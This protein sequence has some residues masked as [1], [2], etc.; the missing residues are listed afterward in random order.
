MRVTSRSACSRHHQPAGAAGQIGHIGAPLIGDQV[1]AGAQPSPSVW[2]AAAR[3][4]RLVI[5]SAMAPAESGAP[6]KGSGWQSHAK[7]IPFPGTR[8][9]GF[10]RW[11]EQL[12]S[13]LPIRAGSRMGRSAGKA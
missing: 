3:A 10:R 12:Q 13:A 6:G 9:S 8:T 5:S 2:S 1:Q 7:S 11:S 4:L